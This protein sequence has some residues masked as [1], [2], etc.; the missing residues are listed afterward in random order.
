MSYNNEGIIPEAEIARVFQAAGRRGS[1]QRV[2]RRYARYRSDSDGK[3]RRYA[4]DRVTEYLYY[5]R[6]R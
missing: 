2:A 4:A 5:V 6:L 3:S 1:Y